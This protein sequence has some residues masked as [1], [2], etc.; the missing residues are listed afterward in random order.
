MPAPAEET[1]PLRLWHGPCT[2]IAMTELYGFARSIRPTVRSLARAPAFAI[3]VTAI[4]ALGIGANTAI[5]SLVSAVLLKPLPFS[6]PEKLVFLW[7]D[8]SAIG[9]SA[10]GPVAPA[11][12]VAWRERSRSFEDVAAFETTSYNLTGDGEPERLSALRTTPNLLSI[13]GMQALVGRTFAPD[14]VAE[15][16]PVVVVS[17]SLWTRRFGAD[18]NVVD[19]EILLDGARYTVIGVVPPHFRFP[20]NAVDVFMPTAF[21]PEELAESGEWY[22]YVVA[23][24]TAGATLAQAQTEMTAIANTIADENGFNRGRGVA[25]TALQEHIARQARPTLLT[26]LGAVGVLLLIACANVANLLLA[27]GAGRRHELALRKALGAGN[28]RIVRHLMIESSALAFAGVVLGIGLAVASFGYL[29]RLVPGTFPGGTAPGLDWRVLAFTAAVALVTVLMFGLGPAWAAARSSV[30]EM[31]HKGAGRGRTARGHRLRNTLIVAEIA[32]T[33]V[34]LAAAGL[35]L[36]SYVSVLRADPGFDPDNL[37]VAVTVLPPLQYEDD[38]RRASFYARVLE[39]VEALP[40]VTDAGYTNFVPLAVRGGFVLVSPEGAP[41]LTPETFGRY[42]VSDRVVTPGYFETLRQPLISGRRFD[43]RDMA[44]SAPP[45]VVINET[46]AAKYWPDGNALGQRFRRGGRDETWWTVIGVVGDVRQMGLDAPPEPELYRSGTQA[47]TDDPFF[48]PKHLLVR[49]A[50]D[51]LSL[52]GAVREA[53]WRVD[54]SQPVSMPNSM[55]DIFVAQLANRDTQLTLVSAFAALALVLA[56]A[57]LYGVLSYTVAQRTSEIGLR[58][59]LGAERG[60]VVRTVVRG[61][62]VLA[63]AGLVCGV[64]GALVLARLLES[65]L[66][67]VSPVDPMTFVGA[68]TLLLLVSAAAAYVP[69]R[70]AANVDPMAALREE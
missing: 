33:A 1:T 37:L 50:T 8:S 36:R 51:P 57:G 9:G 34:L 6:E 55:G 62:L 18:P 3:L 63:C 16:T 31:L 70:R 52:A 66:F 54:P 21:T 32:L 4:L 11:S 5:F 43:E 68:A 58:M 39:E 42:V 64:A 47:A 30:S 13:L 46:M 22:M 27:R 38:T 41:P 10:R 44:D 61:G 26:L 59:A 2:S 20:T 23:R 67:R 19:R 29:A 53:I 49:T 25:V 40:G 35:L 45:A 17:E 60:N 69:A 12:Y 14:E 15:S 28:A 56:A 48:W 7:E 24:L 65:F